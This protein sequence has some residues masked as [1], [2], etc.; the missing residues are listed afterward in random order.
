MINVSIS[1][2]A[3][4]TITDVIFDYNG[5][6]AVDGILIA[7]VDK[8]LTTL[9]RKLKIHV[10]T[11]DSLGTAKK[12]LTGIPCTVH[13]VPS[14]E[15][16]LAKQQYLQQLNAKNTIAIGNGRNDRQIMHDTAIGILILGTEG[17]SVHALK[18][19]DILVANIFD[20]I[21]LLEHP[22]RLLATLR[23]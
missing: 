5:T 14:L 2:F 20:A 7:G 21:N 22:G 1:G 10:V 18:E 17:A 19:A 23:S 11:G 12:E 4:L 15:Q 3:D 13:I 9:A 6:L 16:G 8:L